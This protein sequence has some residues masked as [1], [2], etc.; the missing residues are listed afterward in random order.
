MFN[1][2]KYIK[3]IKNKI[4]KSDS[5]N[6]QNSQKNMEIIFNHLIDSVE[7]RG[8]TV[9]VKTKKNLIVATQGDFVQI[10][11]GAHVMLSKEIHLNPQI[12]FNPDKGSDMHLLQSKLDEAKEKEMLE[13]SQDL[14]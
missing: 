9:I 3:K 11:T 12:S 7:L 6:V 14:S 2:K 10:N 13:L 5:Q 4:I 8:D 1:I